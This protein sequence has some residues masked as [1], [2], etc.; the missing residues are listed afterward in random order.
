M[1]MS[2]IK[3]IENGNTVIEFYDDC[4]SNTESNLNEN[5]KRIYDCINSF[6]KKLN[7][8]EI[9]DLFYTNKE[10]EKVEYI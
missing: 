3:K 7:E 6:S 8:Q 10:L 2:L 5:I 1:S 4:I 9:T